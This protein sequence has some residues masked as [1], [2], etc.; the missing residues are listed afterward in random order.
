VY[1][2]DEDRVKRNPD[3]LPRSGVPQFV[4]RKKALENLHKQL[5]ELERVAISTLIGMGGIGKTELALQYALADRDKDLEKR[6]YKS[7]ICWINVSD[8]GNVGTQILNFAQNY[9][10]ISILEEGELE[11]RVKHCWQFWEKEDTLIIFDDVREY[12]QIKDFLPPQQ[13]RFKIIITTRKKRLAENI[14]VFALEVLD[15]KSALELIISFIGEERI[16]KELKEAKLVCKDLGYLP[17][18]L[19]LV[20][21]FLK[22]RQNWLISKYRKR[23]IQNHLKTKGLEEPSP[24][25]TAQEGVKEAFEISWQELDEEAKEI[26]YYL[27][28]FEVAPIPY[29]LIKELCPIE[30]EDDLE[31]ILEDSLI[32]SSL[33]KN[34]DNQVYEIHT[35]IHQY[36]REKLEESNLTIEVKKAYCQLMV[37]ISK[38]I[39]EQPIKTDIKGLTLIIPHLSVAA[40]ELNEWINDED[41]IWP[42]V[43]ISRFYKGQGFYKEAEPWDKQCLDITKKRLEEDHPNVADSLNNLAL[44]YYNQGR[45][46]E[47]EPLYL[48]ALKL[49][50]KLLGEDHPDVATSLNNLALLYKNQG[51]YE[52]AEP[53]C[54][55]ALELYKKLLGEDHPNVATSLNNL[56]NLYKN[57]GRYEE[58]EPLCLQ[59]LELYKKLLGEDHP[60][61]ATSLNNLANLYKNQGRYEEAEPL[62]LQALELRKKLLGEDHPNVAQ[63]LNNLAKLYK[64]QG[65]YEEA[66]PLYLQ[67]VDMGK[68]LLGEDHPYT[69]KF[70]QN[71]ELMKKE[72]ESN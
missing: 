64:N 20:A 42:Y 43:G 34:L 71:Y 4:G 63:S 16:N 3:N 59:A 52:E 51:R 15:E 67:A 23:L 68:K 44:L 45:Y 65:R 8:K 36:L 46:E 58:A 21:R 40:K 69:K 60:N 17:L 47:A 2:P 31:D 49:R 11:E 5:Q 6:N 29:Q 14:K 33:I 37:N 28:L 24:E 70:K 9:L 66:E 61:V 38:E 22:R 19:E 53:L 62:C 32:N 10:K 25:M 48:Q 12:Q 18:G 30:D 27:S 7:G 1:S 26:A 57:Q 35:L 41:L 56:A 55:Q 39:P 13:K 54:L 50:K 72:I